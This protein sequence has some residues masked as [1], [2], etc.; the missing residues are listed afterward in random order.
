MVKSTRSLLWPF[1]FLKWSISPVIWFSI[2]LL[3][4][5][6]TMYK[7][8][9][10]AHSYTHIYT[11]LLTHTH[12]YVYTH[13]LTQIHTCK[14]IYIHT[15]TDPLKH[16]FRFLLVQYTSIQISLSQSDPIIFFSWVIT[17]IPWKY[18]AIQEI[19]WDIYYFIK[20]E[21]LNRFFLF[22]LII[23]LHDSLIDFIPN[24]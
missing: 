24:S 14:L 6:I 18:P 20:E 10:D 17:R 15:N 2:D 8:H 21:Y 16:I 22:F 12:I 23:N 4:Y 19:F 13:S 1:V 9:T 11:N 7:L 3:S 5:F